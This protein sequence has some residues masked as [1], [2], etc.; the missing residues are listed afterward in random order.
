M[1]RRYGDSEGI[2][3]GRGEGSGPHGT[4]ALRWQHWGGFRA[5]C[6]VGRLGDQYAR[7]AQRRHRLRRIGK[8]QGFDRS[9]PVKL[10]RDAI[11]CGQLGTIGIGVELPPRLV[12][13]K[14]RPVCAVTAHEHVGTA[15][16]REHIAAARANQ[17]VT[18]GAALERVVARAAVD[19]VVTRAG[20]DPV[21]EGIACQAVTMGRSDQIFDG[22]AGIDR[23]LSGRG[24]GAGPRRADEPPVTGF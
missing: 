3:I 21:C 15:A 20:L 18:P 19:G 10:E 7:Y 13:L 9:Q 23:D 5:A 22:G 24:D 8:L 14:R 6:K 17:A 11:E 4:Q 1:T 12:A 2:G 16:P